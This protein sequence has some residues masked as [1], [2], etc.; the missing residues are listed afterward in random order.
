VSRLAP[1]P[2]QSP[3]VWMLGAVSPGTKQLRHKTD[4]SHLSNAKI[5]NLRNHMTSISDTLGKPSQ[6]NWKF[7]LVCCWH[8]PWGARDRILCSVRSLCMPVRR[9]REKGWCDCTTIVR[10]L[11]HTS[12]AGIAKCG[13]ALQLSQQFDTLRAVTSM[14][15]MSPPFK[16]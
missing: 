1:G 8:L 15:C 7:I 6:S 14:L 3:V 16:F 10:R 13:P 12:S 11:I 4:N 2:V 9:R 5:K